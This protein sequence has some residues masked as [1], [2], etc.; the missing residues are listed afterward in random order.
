MSLAPTSYPSLY[1]LPRTQQNPAL[2]T[3][4]IFIS[5]KSLF[6][7][8]NSCNTHVAKRRNFALKASETEP[9]A[10]PEAGGG[11]EEEEKYET[12]EI[13][14]EQPYGLK[15]RKGRDGGTYIDAILPGGFADKTGKFTVGDRVIATRFALFFSH[16]LNFDYLYRDC[17][18]NLNYRTFELAPVS[19]FALCN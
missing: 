19:I 6:L 14:V 17:D 1:S 16:P 15:F 4:P 12:Y 10:K 13:E 8:S 18:W 5:A 3:Q 11:E 2:I 7:S 9:T